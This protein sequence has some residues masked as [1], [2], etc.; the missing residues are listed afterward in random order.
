MGKCLR[1]V[2]WP[3]NCR[4][5]KTT[6]PLANRSSQTEAIYTVLMNLRNL[7]REGLRIW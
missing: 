1:I 7:V 6:S 5:I 3:I 4:I 2:Y